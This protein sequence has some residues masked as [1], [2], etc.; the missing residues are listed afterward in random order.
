MRIFVAVS[1]TFTKKQLALNDFYLESQDIHT[2]II[3]GTK[4]MVKCSTK[5]RK[6]GSE[7]LKVE[8]LMM[9]CWHTAQ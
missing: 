7:S 1:S 3:R 6:R 9:T 4:R 5:Q 2:Y 8:E